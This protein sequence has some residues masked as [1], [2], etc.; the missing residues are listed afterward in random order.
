MAKGKARRRRKFKK[1]L[2][3]QIRHTLALGTLASA[4]LV[5]SNVGDTVTEKAWVTSVIGTWSL[6]A[7]TKAAGVGPIM[8]GLAHSDYS[9]AEIEAFI[10]N[11]GSWEEGDQV[12]QEVARRKIRI[13]GVFDVTDTATE[14]DVLNDGKPI[15][16]KCGWMLTTG[17]TV[18]FWCYNTGANPL[19]TTDPQ[20][21]VQGHANLW[22]I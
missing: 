10:E 6:S 19:A 20:F 16:T 9:D 13:V 11:A 17:Q 1:Y 14:D 8:C 15:R 18:K 2:R 5:G 7:M 3:G 4:T 21:K 22:P 12:E